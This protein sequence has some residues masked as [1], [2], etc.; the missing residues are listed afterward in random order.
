MGDGSL[1]LLLVDTDPIFRLGLKT[2]VDELS[3]ATLIATGDRPGTLTILGNQGKKTDPPISVV[4]IDAITD[5]LDPNNL[6][7]APW[8]LCEEIRQTYPQI[9]I[10][11]LGNGL[12]E[13]A[14]I[15]AQRAGASGYCTKNSSAS[16]IVA[17]ARQAQ[18]GETIWP[19]LPSLTPKDDES[20][21]PIQQKPSLKF[22][23]NNQG[24]REI[25]RAMEQLEKMLS[26]DNLAKPKRLGDRLQKLIIE[27]RQRELRAAR[28][29]VITVGGG[30]VNKPGTKANN[31]QNYP[32][33]PLSRQSDPTLKPTAQVVSSTSSRTQSKAEASPVSKSLPNT[34]SS[35]NLG[36]SIGSRLNESALEDIDKSILMEIQN[37][38]LD[39]CTS[40]LIN[41]QNNQT[42]APLEIDILKTEQ[43]RDLIYLVLRKVDDLLIS[44]RKQKEQQKTTV[45]SA[46][47][48]EQDNRKIWED[49]LEDFF[50]G[51]KT[52]NINGQ[53]IDIFPILKSD[54]DVIR[55][56][57]LSRAVDRDNKVSPDIMGKWI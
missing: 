15:R 51:Y 30:F 52:C 26:Q 8:S 4:L 23:W 12:S 27:G 22:K 1:R 48:S 14:L 2:G 41:A 39:R 13:I 36:V 7:Y 11:V 42:G 21:S 38:L 49:A 57:I 47:I 35:S 9:P 56:D 43:R 5:G 31:T 10:L 16:R 6:V 45:S 34:E 37:S 55:Q 46:S 33:N 18:R 54:W 20:P 19:A 24:L 28:L 3:G 50:K 29:V 25:D 17:I 53:A 44:L 40:K 32:T